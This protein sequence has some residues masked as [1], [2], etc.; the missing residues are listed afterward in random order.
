M[1]PRALVT[2]IG[3]LEEIGIEP[4]VP[5]GFPEQRFVSP[6]CAGCNNHPVKIVF[7]YGLLDAFLSIDGACVEVV[8][9]VHHMGQGLYIFPHLRHVDHSTDITAAMTYKN[10]YSRLLA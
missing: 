3:H 9:S 2:N 7:L 4:C 10:A 6:G 8:L 5:H 1:H